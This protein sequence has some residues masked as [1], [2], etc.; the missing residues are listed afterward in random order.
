MAKISVLLTDAEEARFDAYCDQ[1]G[2]K[3]STLIA[4]LIREFL[5]H[6]GYETQPRLF[7]DPASPPPAFGK[8]V[9]R[10]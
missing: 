2:Y 3:K 4:R 9:V 5:D 1:K 10:K 7:T 8:P 6:E